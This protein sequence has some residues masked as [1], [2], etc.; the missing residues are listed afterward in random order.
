MSIQTA[1]GFTLLVQLYNRKGEKMKRDEVV[2]ILREQ[3]KE[4]VESYNITYLSLFGSAAF[5][6]IRQDK[7]VG[8]LVKFARP[9]GL[10][11]F[12]DLKRR[13]EI[14]L[15][16]KVDIGKPHSL[17]PEVKARILQEAIRVF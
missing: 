2:R 1:G 11:Q 15:G 3:Q 10:F 17:K 5:G 7:G 12:M 6:E 8:I 16:C 14:L 13:L 9:T 4:L